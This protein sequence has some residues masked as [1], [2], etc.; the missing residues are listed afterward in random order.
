M[1]KSNWASLTGQWILAAS[2]EVNTK[3]NEISQLLDH[4]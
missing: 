2:Y 1:F 3:S 4:F